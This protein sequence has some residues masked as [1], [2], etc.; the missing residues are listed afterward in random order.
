[1]VEVARELPVFKYNLKPLDNQIIIRRTAVCSVC[2]KETDYVYEGFFYS[3]KEIRNICPWCVANGKAAEKYKGKFQDIA[4]CEKVESSEYIDELIHR[5]P[6]YIGWKKEQWLSHCGDFCTFVGYIRGEE[7]LQLVD[8]LGYDLERV[9][10]VNGITQ[11]AL[12]KHLKNNNNL[13]GYLF[14]CVVCG[15][16]R[17]AV[18]CDSE[19][20]INMYKPPKAV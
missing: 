5:T 18:D 20:W 17:L 11:E 13:Q 4:L 6:G 12:D 3:K 9:K 8:E 10:R 2:N 19:K 16:H 1:M 7:I 14:K 15:K